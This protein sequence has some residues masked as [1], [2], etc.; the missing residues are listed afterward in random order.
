MISQS[1]VPH[2]FRGDIIPGITLAQVS[3]TVD[4]QKAGRIKVRFMIGGAPALESDWVPVMSFFAGAGSGAFFLPQVGDLA[5]VSF[6]DGDPDMPFVLGFLWNGGI[7]PPG[8]HEKQQDQRVI[9]TKQGKRIEFDDSKQGSLTISDEKNNMV[10][11]DTAKNAITVS[12]KGDITIEAAGK[13]TLK[14][15]EVVIQ[16]TGGSVKLSLSAASMKV[17]GGQSMKLAATMIDLN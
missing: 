3:N 16:N 9:R 2:L 1:M 15:A 7:A 13:I 14:G 5:V 10:R 17:N 12:S 6:A 8:D 4:P 11:F